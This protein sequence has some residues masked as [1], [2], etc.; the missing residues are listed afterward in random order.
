MEVSYYIYSAMKRFFYLFFICF[1]VIELS[2]CEKTRDNLSL[3]WSM[4]EMGADAQDIIL[5]ANLDAYKIWIYYANENVWETFFWN[6]FQ[7][8]GGHFDGGWFA[9]D[10]LNN[11]ESCQIRISVASNETGHS[12]WLNLNIEAMV[13]GN[14]P[15]QHVDATVYQSASGHGREIYSLSDKR[16]DMVSGHIIGLN[17]NV[18]APNGRIQTG[19]HNVYWAKDE[20][21]V[22][23]RAGE[24][25]EIEGPWFK[26]VPDNWNPYG[27]SGDFQP[28]DTGG[29]R[30]LR[31]Y[32]ERKEGTNAS[33][34]IQNP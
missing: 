25:G 4:C 2:S 33:L 30:I 15:S 20:N 22:V 34:I 9:L 11:E 19:K 13:G 29:W 3:S 6:D 16:Q 28:N 5:E 24:D 17:D 23:Y 10:I 12:R 8:D 7:L 14:P 21:D 1:L 18:T 32:V 31:F 27:L 26:L